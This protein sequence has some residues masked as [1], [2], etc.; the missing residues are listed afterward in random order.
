MVMQL[1]LFQDKAQQTERLKNQR[2]QRIQ[3]LVEIARVDL[4]WD[5]DFDRDQLVSLPTS[6]DIYH[7]L[8]REDGWEL[9]LR[10]PEGC[11]THKRVRD[12]TERD[13][14]RIQAWRKD[15]LELA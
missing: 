13:I 12:L 9:D 8:E 10:S 11:W 14:Q 7:Y 5:P 6:P 1:S 15:V 2:R 4:T 3:E